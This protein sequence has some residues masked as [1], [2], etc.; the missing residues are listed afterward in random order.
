MKIPSLV[1]MTAGD[2]SWETGQVNAHLCGSALHMALSWS[3]P[4]PPTVVGIASEQC[5]RVV[6]HLHIYEN[7]CPTPKHNSATQQ[8]SVTHLTQ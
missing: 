6:G 7:T 2:S 3:L 1:G 5:C 4:T 8:T